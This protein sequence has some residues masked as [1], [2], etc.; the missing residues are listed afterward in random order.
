[1][2]GSLLPRVCKAFELPQRSVAFEVDS[3]ALFAAR[4]DVPTQVAPVLTYP[5][6]KEDVAL[7]VDESVTAGELAAVIRQAAGE[8]LQDL[9][10]FDV[11]VGSQVPEGRSRLPSRCVCGPDHTLTAEE[12]AGVRK[13]IIKQARKKFG[14]ELR[15]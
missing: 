7:V 15:G 13:R 14:A 1:M 12:T 4:G 2:Q 5:A 6:A 10:L 9:R 8:L 3:D 11:Y